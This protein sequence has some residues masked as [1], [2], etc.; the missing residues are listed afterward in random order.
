MNDPPVLSSS[1]ASPPP[2]RTLA[3]LGCVGGFVVTL[4]VISGGDAW[5]NNVAEGGTVPGNPMVLLAVVWALAAAV[6]LVVPVVGGRWPTVGA[7]VAFLC[8]AGGFAGV[9]TATIGAMVSP[10]WGEPTGLFANPRDH[11]FLAVVWLVA[12]LPLVGAGVLLLRK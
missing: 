1:E 8:A 11:L 10:L 6:A 12:A 5:A 3:I 9:M 2:W 4:V 7:V